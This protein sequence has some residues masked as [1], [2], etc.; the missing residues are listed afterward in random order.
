MGPVMGWRMVVGL[1]RVQC[2]PGCPDEQKQDQQTEATYLES[3]ILQ[4][5]LLGTPVVQACSILPLAI[6]TARKTDSVAA[7][8]HAWCENVLSAQNGTLSGAAT[9]R[10]YSEGLNLWLDYTRIYWYMQIIMAMW[11]VWAIVVFF[12]HLP[13][14]AHTILRIR[15]ALLV[16]TRK[17]QVEDGRIKAQT[18]DLSKRRVNELQ[19]PEDVGRSTITVFPPSRRKHRCLANG[20][21]TTVRRSDEFA[22]SRSSS[23]T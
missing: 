8:F 13:V 14:V 1:R 21:A 5:H 6:V 19:R 12:V 2:V 3:F 7:R 22:S 11:C 18:V 20:R 16:A 4:S 15:T 17:N 9:S 10:L 23:G